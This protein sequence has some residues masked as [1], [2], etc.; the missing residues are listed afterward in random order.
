M[1]LCNELTYSGSLRCGSEGVANSVLHLDRKSELKNDSSPLWLLSALD[2]DISKSVCF[3]NT[4]NYR[5]DQPE[6]DKNHIEAELV[7]NI[8][9]LLIQVCNHLQFFYFLFM[10]NNKNI[11][12]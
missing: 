8:L 1:R 9:Q 3:I 6:K 4:E 2:N 12:I 11:C 7:I 5:N 10:V